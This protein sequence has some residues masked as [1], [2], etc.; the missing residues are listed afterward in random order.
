MGYQEGLTECISCL[1]IICYLTTDLPVPDTCMC[2][3]AMSWAHGDM[4]FQRGKVCDTYENSGISGEHSG[5]LVI[6]G[7]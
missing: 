3:Y 4:L 6:L 1:L 2:P 7:N 5:I